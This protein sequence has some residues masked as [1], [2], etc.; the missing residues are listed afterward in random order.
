VDRSKVW[1]E[2]SKKLIKKTRL[3]ELFNVGF[4][5]QISGK[6]GMFN[7][8]ETSDWVNIIPITAE[9]KV[10]LV[11]Q[12]RFGTREV[13]LEFPGG[14]INSGEQPVDAAKRELVEETGCV[15]ASVQALGSCKP[16]PAFLNNTCHYYL[17][18]AVEFSKKQSLDPMEEIACDLVVLSEID[19]MIKSGKINHSLTIA[20]WS[21][22][23]LRAGRLNHGLTGTEDTP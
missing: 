12:F 23:Q 21:F 5:S 10:V 13:T 1:L 9:N 11:R 16:N 3:F 4:K 20:G 17:A 22:Y 14:S 6:F 15:G 19:E 18:K 7:V 2:T 8:I